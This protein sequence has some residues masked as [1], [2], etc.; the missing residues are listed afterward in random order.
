MVFFEV[1]K[2]EDDIM[3]IGPDCMIPMKSVSTIIRYMNED[4]SD[5]FVMRL[6]NNKKINVDASCVE[7]LK[8]NCDVLSYFVTVDCVI[9]WRCKFFVLKDV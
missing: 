7:T 9:P 6:S 1:V 5:H 3:L 8:Q 4:A 2:N